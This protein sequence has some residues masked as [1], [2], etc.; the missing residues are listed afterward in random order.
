[1]EE[2]TTEQR[3]K[4]IQRELKT[5]NNH[6]TEVR[7]DQKDTKRRVDLIDW[8]VDSIATW[9]KLLFGA[10]VTG[11]IACIIATLV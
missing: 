4:E 2:P 7:Q 3:I 5:L 9:Q 8:K 10:I 1:M 11:A 6:I